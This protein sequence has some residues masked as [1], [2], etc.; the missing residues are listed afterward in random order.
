M[1]ISKKK[2]KEFDE[3]FKFISKNDFYINIELFR[4]LYISDFF[5]HFLLYVENKINDA[6]KINDTIIIHINISVISIED[7]YYYDK[8]I[9]F[10]KYLH[11]YTNN[12]KKIFIYGSSI[13]FNNFI[14]LINLSLGININEKII[15]TDDFDKIKLTL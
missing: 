2:K 9:E 5:E 12:I 15:F 4:N 3:I 10:I 11:K 14:Y 7:T 8:I 13:F 6:L 1:E